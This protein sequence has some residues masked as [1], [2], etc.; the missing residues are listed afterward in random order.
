MRVDKLRRRQSHPLIDRY[1][2]EVVTFEDFEK[3]HRRGAGILDIMA[4]GKGNETNVAGT[5]VEG[6][7]LTRRPSTPMRP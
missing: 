1:I 2:G 6:A 5:K 4:L 3:A 7:R